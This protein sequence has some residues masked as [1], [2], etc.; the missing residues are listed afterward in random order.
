MTL[1]I[2]DK[3]D[4]PEDFNV[5]AALKAGKGKLDGYAYLRPWLQTWTISKADQ[6][7]VQSTVSEGGMGGMLWSNTANYSAS[8]LPDR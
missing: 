1:A 6:R 7:A 4:R 2:R 3:R 5:D 8:A